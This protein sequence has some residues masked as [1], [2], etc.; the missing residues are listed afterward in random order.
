MPHQHFE[1]AVIDRHI[2]ARSG[3]RILDRDVEIFT[4][5]Y[6]GD[7]SQGGGQIG[8]IAREDRRMG[9]DLGAA[10]GRVAVGAEMVVEAPVAHVV[11][12]AQQFD[13]VTRIGRMGHHAVEGR[14]MGQRLLP[15]AGA[16][17]NADTRAP[18]TGNLVARPQHLA[19]PQAFRLHMRI[20]VEQG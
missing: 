14:E 13:G 5:A 3:K 17:A 8:A 19:D 9:A 4:T 10:A 20:A 11:A 6:F 16:V 1:I 12:Q 7:R 18:A 15:R 2:Y